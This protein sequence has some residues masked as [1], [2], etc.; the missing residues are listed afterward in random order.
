MPYEWDDEKREDTLRTRGVDFESMEYFDWDT[1]LTYR[2]DRHGEVRWSS[3]G[4]IGDRLY[5]VAWTL[6][7]DSTR[8]I[9]LRKANAG[10]TDNYDN[11]T[12]EDN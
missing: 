8:I 5:H 12:S 10:E 1:A 7:G 11:Q 3:Y 2:S 4:L 6:R 9:S